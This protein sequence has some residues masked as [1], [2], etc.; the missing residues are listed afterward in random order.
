MAKDPAFLFYTGDFQVGTQFFTNEQ[1]GIY[2]RLLMAQH[3]HG[4]LCEDEVIFIC[5]KLDPKIMSK[6]LQDED[7]KYYNFRLESEVNKRKSY[8]ESRSNNKAGKGKEHKKKTRKSYVK[9]MEDENKD[10]DVIKIKENDIEKFEKFRKKY[11][12]TKNGTETEFKNF[13][14]HKDWEAILPTLEIAVDNQTLE[15]K[16]KTERKEFVPEWKNLQTWINQRCWEQEVKLVEEKPK[17]EYK[18]P[19]YREI[20]GTNR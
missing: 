12:G 1:V 14:R 20:F 17:E 6:F 13:Q 16:Q 2:L 15:R 4:H 8:S 18:K 10:K 19:N 9:H 11:G 5:G 7:G 3:Q